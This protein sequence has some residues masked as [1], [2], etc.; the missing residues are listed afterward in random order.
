MKILGIGN[1]LV[2]V[3]VRLEDEKSLSAFGLEK[4]GMILLGDEE[5]S[6]IAPVM[7][8]LKPEKATGGSAGNVILALA[9]LQRGAGYVGCVGDDANGRFFADT[10]RG[11]GAETRLRTSHRP[12]GTANTFITPDGE[13][14]FGTYLGA[15]LDLKVED[16]IPELFE[17]YD[18]LH[19]EGY[20][21]QSPGLLEA[22]CRVAKQKG[23]MLS[24]DLASYTVVRDCR[25][26]MTRLVRDYID[27]VFANQEESEAFTGLVDPI[28]SAKEMARLCQLAVVK[29]GGDGACVAQHD[30]NEEPVRV[31]AQR[32]KV[33]DTTAA[34]DF[35]AAGFLHAY[36]EGRQ[37]EACLRMGAL[38][39]SEVIQ[40]IGTQVTK[41][42]WEMV[43]NA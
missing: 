40:V 6:R 42:R 39:A 8:T 5:E 15:A 16:I 33:V 35:F 22:I 20:L 7:A 36:G 11:A 3:L 34:G 14:T 27:I 37:M 12:T 29:M 31:A 24:I 28:A 9:H 41:E 23:M 21:I 26:E 10:F 38:L 4:G 1:A 25:E 13:R 2:D 30:S 17:G 43:V 18:L 19:I 32:V